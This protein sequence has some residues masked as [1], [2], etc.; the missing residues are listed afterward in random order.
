ML[1]N[2]K[3]DHT[4]FSTEVQLRGKAD[5]AKAEGQRSKEW[6][7]FVSSKMIER[8]LTEPT[9]RKTVRDDKKSGDL[10]SESWV[11]SDAQKQNQKKMA[12]K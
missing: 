10:K 12:I 5:S 6:S 11:I 2:G 1:G 4:P 8:R 9:Q 3:V 7:G